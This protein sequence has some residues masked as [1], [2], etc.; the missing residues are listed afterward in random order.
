MYDIKFLLLFIWN[1]NLTLWPVFYWAAQLYSMS[2]VRLDWKEGS[3]KIW[4]VERKQ[5]PFGSSC[6]FLLIWLASL[7]RKRQRHL[8]LLCLLL[9]PPAVSPAPRQ[10]RVCRSPTKGPH[11]YRRS[12]APRSEATR[13]N[14]G[15][16]PFWGRGRFPFVLVNLH[17]SLTPRPPPHFISIV[18]SQLPA[19]LLHWTQRQQTYRNC[20]ASSCSGVKP[21]PCSKSAVLIWT[22]E[23]SHG[24]CCV[25]GHYL[26]LDCITSL[27]VQKGFFR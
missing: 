16:H 11:L 17:L 23:G 24:F 27:S 10:G 21:V 14:R 8:K 25:L 18:L 9:D 20:S 15:C 6:M 19:R 13:T 3:W 26:L 12:S 22:P 4:R 2:L 7:V 1:L 5:Q